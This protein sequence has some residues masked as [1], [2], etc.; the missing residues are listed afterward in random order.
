MST[1]LDVTLEWYEL[2][3]AATVGLHR[4]LSAL[5]DARPDRHGYSGE[6]SW[7]VHIEGAAGEA[8]FAKCMDRY[9]GGP[10]DS[11]KVG[12][13]V[14]AIQVRTRSRHSYE[15]IVRPDDRDSDTFVLVTGR[16][17]TFRV[18]GYIS[19]ADAKRPEFLRTHGDRPAA[20][21]VPH[22]A[23][24]SLANSLRRHAA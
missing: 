7:G 13:D 8:A 6:D 19:G 11:F 17:P 4:Q 16:A 18:V 2:L 1:Y 23:L 22:S 24:T 14:G 5:R 15:L 10:I 20:Y 9:W 12:G 3:A 21:F